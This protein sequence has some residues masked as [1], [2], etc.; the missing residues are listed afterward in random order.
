MNVH[1]LNVSHLSRAP[2]PPCKVAYPMSGTLIYTYVFIGLTFLSVILF[3]INRIRRLSA[4]V[5]V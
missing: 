5:T 3:L 2:E 4:R 1:Y